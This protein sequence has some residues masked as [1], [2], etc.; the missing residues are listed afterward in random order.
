MTIKFT[1]ENVS[2]LEANDDE[3]KNDIN[4]GNT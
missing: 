3:R 1:H 2:A 4:L